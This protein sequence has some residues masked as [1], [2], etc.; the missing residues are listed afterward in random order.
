MVAP[1][2][3]K[4]AEQDVL[5]NFHTAFQS[6]SLA[7]SYVLDENAVVAS[8]FKMDTDGFVRVGVLPVWV[9]LFSACSKSKPTAPCRC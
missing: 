5:G 1:T 2:S 3:K 4:Q 7:I 8:D 6:E 9:G